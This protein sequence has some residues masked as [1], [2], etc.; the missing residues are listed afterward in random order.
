[1]GFGPLLRSTALSFPSLPRLVGSPESPPLPLLTATQLGG[2]EPRGLESRDV[3]AQPFL[4]PMGDAS[5][6]LTPP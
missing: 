2:S 1:M 5:S 3:S 4:R 6:P